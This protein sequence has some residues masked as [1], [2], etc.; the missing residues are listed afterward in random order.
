MSIIIGSSS[1]GWGA[2]P[3]IGLAE[4]LRSEPPNGAVTK[5]PPWVLVKPIDTMPAA[6]ACSISSP[7]LP[8]CP[9]RF[10]GQHTVAA[11][12]DVHRTLHRHATN[13]LAEPKVSVHT[14]GVRV[15]LGDIRLCRRYHPAVVN[16]LAVRGH[17]DDP[18]RVVIPSVREH[19]RI[20]NDVYDARRRVLCAQ[21]R[22]HE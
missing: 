10:I 9:E 3:T 5:P 8:R 14:Q 13:V 17:A 11:P 22:Y 18:V 12:G 19:Q 1:P 2:P 4:S 16:P 20:G 7:T 15:G 21:Q 6:A